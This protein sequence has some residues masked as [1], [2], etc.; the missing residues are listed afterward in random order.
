M[1]VRYGSLIN[2][3]V[4]VVVEPEEF[5][6]HELCAVVGYDGVWDPKSVDDVHEELHGLLGFDHRDCR[7][8]IHFVNLST[9]TSKCVKPPS[10]LLRGPTRLS[11]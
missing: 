4:V 7:A 1:G 6:P 11:P 5:L 10:A 8:S 3:D 9:A 2:V